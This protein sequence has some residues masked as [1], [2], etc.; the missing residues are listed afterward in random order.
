MTSNHIDQLAEWWENAEEG[1]VQPG[2]TVIG[3]T[4]A[5]NDAYEVF[6]AQSG[7]SE[8]YDFYRILSRAP[9]PKPA[10]RD[11]VAVMAVTPGRPERRA[12]IRYDEPGWWGDVDS[13]YETDELTDVTPLV[14]AKVTDETLLRA[15]NAAHGSSARSLDW[16]SDSE[17]GD[18]RDALTAALGLETA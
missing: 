9:I 6:V 11:A 16:Y 15:L 3:L 13:S 12:F 1:V 10:W 18:M 2:D 8:E 17:A 5:D 4:D 14:E 7:E